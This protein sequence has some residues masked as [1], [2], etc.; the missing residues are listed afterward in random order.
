[1]M[2]NSWYT[3]Y[4]ATGQFLCHEKRPELCRYGVDSQTENLVYTNEKFNIADEH[5]YFHL[6]ANIQVD[7]RNPREVSET[8]W[9][10][11]PVPKILFDRM[12]KITDLSG[13]FFVYIPEEKFDRFFEGLKVSYYNGELGYGIQ[14]QTQKY[15]Q[16]FFRAMFRLVTIHIEDGLDPSL[17]SKTAIKINNL[18]M[19]HVGPWNGKFEFMYDKPNYDKPNKVNKFKIIQFTSDQFVL[20]KGTPIVTLK[21]DNFIY[22]YFHQ[23]L[24]EGRSMMMDSNILPNSC[25]IFNEG[26]R[27][28]LAPAAPSRSSTIYNIINK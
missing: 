28:I 20:S 8:C 2:I 10:R 22:N 23:I 6:D 21:V 5:P 25:Q 4:Y 26:S 11:L 19:Q 16:S 24:P 17:L 15:N 12:T 1:M 14:V 7:D 18:L 13:K 9:V 3:N 27:F